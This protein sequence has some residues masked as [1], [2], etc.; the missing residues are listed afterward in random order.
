MAQDEEV[1]FRA[2]VLSLEQAG[3]RPGHFAVSPTQI[4]ARLGLEMDPGLD[5]LATMKR[6]GLTPVTKRDPAPATGA[7][8]GR[9]VIQGELGEGGMG[10]V[11]TARDPELGRLVALK[12]MN[13]AG[14]INEPLVAQFISEARIAS[15]LEHPNIV[16]VHELSATEDGQVFFTMKKIEGRSLQELLQ[17]LVSNAELRA[18][19]TQ[20]RL[21]TV[22]VQV[23]NAL[24]Y[25]HSRGFIHRDIKPAN[26]MCGEFGDVY[27]V[28]WG[29]ARQAVPLAVGESQRDRLG[30]DRSLM[31]GTP[32]FMSPEQLA[33]SPASLGPRSDVFSLGA[34][35]YELLTL[36]PAFAAQSLE[37]M[38]SA[39]TLGPPPDPRR[40]TR[41]IIADEIADVCL[42]AMAWGPND[43]FA[44]ARVLADAVEQFLAGSHRREQ[45]VASLDRAVSFLHSADERRARARTLREEAAAKLQ[46]V[47]PHDSEAVKA[48]GWAQQDEG[49][50]L[51]DLAAV[52]E[53]RFLHG[54]HGALEHDP[55]LGRAHEVLADFYRAQHARSEA[56][57][58][59]RSAQRYEF[60]LRSHDH[61]RHVEYLDGSGT[62]SLRT[63]PEGATVR[64][65]VY[66][67]HNRRLVLA[68]RGEL[69]VTPLS[70][71]RL[72][73]GSYLLT[74]SAPGRAEVLYPI[75]VDR[76]SHS[77]S[78]P[79]G[80]S[81]AHA[82]PLPQADALGPDD[83]YV[84]AGFASVGGDPAAAGALP[85][86]R[87]WIDGFIIQ[88]YPV[89]HEQY[90][91]FVNDLLARGQGAEAA[92]R[93][94]REGE[95]Q[96]I[97]YGMDGDGRYEL[98]GPRTTW[99]PDGAVTL[100]DW[101]DARAYARWY[102]ETT[103][104]SWRLPGEL[105]WEKAAR[106]V[107]GRCFPWGDFHDPS[108]SLNLETHVGPA[109]PGRVGSHPI[110]RS[111][112][113]V[114]WL[115]GGVRNWCAEVF[116]PDGPPI[117]QEG[118]LASVVLDDGPPPAAA[119]H[120]ARGG[121]W[122]LPGWV[123]RA[124]VR[125]YHPPIRLADL[126]FR[127]CRSTGG[128]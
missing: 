36:K 1:S 9:H 59:V 48:A 40:G 31:S 78:V 81:D 38:R 35:L 97:I 87:I 113:G 45:A 47:K 25:A 125:G 26:V 29:L 84:P 33:G 17:Q 89:T 95:R 82:V 118:R 67:S 66:V 60:L 106:G 24:G 61:G 117:S 70:R 55:T 16:P 20:R 39:E 50:Q 7:V 127:L 116:S 77:E 94:P 12:V 27:L 30:P 96:E 68:D 37:E 23:C 126:G 80:T 99:P 104:R 115:A 102:A 86:R 42:K 3:I 120:V 54:A 18:H 119:S 10:R 43:R 121:A 8:L 91:A 76:E 74:I 62:F 13:I 64:L 114:C 112:Y 6:T 124:A 63:D 22:F 83:V 5:A 65:A 73:R 109:T 107:D 11:L 98:K 88:R 72:P 100:I 110:D 79:P 49:A 28:D 41:E 105:E 128:E 111:P 21:L 19:W 14:A 57:G 101:D 34:V 15:Q 123:G 85:A 51:E 93:A 56:A 71:V 46:D 58:D 122:A 103:G 53:E 44:D 4:L 2:T 90:L 69:G 75:A 32:G 108:W 52:D 92:L